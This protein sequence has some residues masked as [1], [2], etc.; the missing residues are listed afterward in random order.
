MSTFVPD[1]AVAP[2]LA[3]AQVWKRRALQERAP[4]LGTASVW[5]SGAV[6]SLRKHFVEN[7]DEGEGNFFSKLE[8][9]LK[10][11]P[12]EAKQLAAEMI[13]FMMLCPSR[14][15]AEV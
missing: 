9:Q 10:N 4:L 1:H 6:A 7:L 12:A 3:A 5:T 11:A 8:K 13:W 14:I 15:S 2:I